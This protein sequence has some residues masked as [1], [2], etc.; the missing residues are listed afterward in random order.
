M[1]HA[2]IL[3]VCIALF[4]SMI[5]LV[6]AQE[7]YTGALKEEIM[8]AWIHPSP[9]IEFNGSPDELDDMCDNS[10]GLPPV[11]NQSSQG[12]CT[13][14]ATAYY[15][16]TYLQWQEHGWDL[17][18]PAHQC[19][20]AFT[21][22]TINGGVDGGSYPSDAFLLF[23][24]SG[25]AT[26]EDMPYDAGDYTRYPSEQAFINGMPFRTLETYSINTYTYSGIQNLKNHL[27]NGNIAET[28]ISVWDNFQNIDNYNYTYCINDVYGD[29]PGGH[30]VTVIGFDDDFETTDGTGA[31][32]MVNS[33]GSSW[34]DDGFWW[35]SY[36]AFMDPLISWG[37][38]LYASD[39]I[40]YEPTMIAYANIE[41]G[42]RYSIKPFMGIGDLVDP[43]LR[44]EYYDFYMGSRAN[45]SFEGTS[46]VLDVSD[47]KM[48]VD[49]YAAND[50]FLEID[51]REPSDGHSGT[52]SDFYLFDLEREHFALWHEVPMILP[53]N[54]ASSY[55]ELVLY[56]SAT[57]PDNLSASIDLST[58]YASLAWDAPTELDDFI[59]YVIYRDGIEIGTSNQ[60]VYTDELPE[61]GIYSYEILT[62]WDEC[63]SWLTDPQA[64]NWIEPVSPRFSRI[65]TLD[66]EGH[67]TF[68]WDQLRDYDLFYDDGTFEAPL[69]PSGDAPPGISIAQKFTAP[70]DGQVL[71]IGAYFMETNPDMNGCIQFVLLEAGNNDLPGEVFFESELICPGQDGWL[72]HDFEDERLNCQLEED[73]WVGIRWQDPGLVRLGLDQDGEVYH[74]KALS[75]NGVNWINMVTV[76]NAMIR[77]KFGNEERVNDWTG[78]LGFSLYLNDEL[79]GQISSDNHIISGSLPEHGLYELRVDANYLQ[80]TWIGSPFVFEWDGQLLDVDKNEIPLTWKIGKAYP[81]P[82][83]PSASI[84]VELQKRA[85]L[86]SFVY[87]IM[88]QQV[89]VLAN[90]H[91]SQGTHRLNFNASHLSSGVYFIRT[92]ITGYLTDTQKVMLVR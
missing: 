42:D 61:F 30:A 60:V 5:P 16:L 56:Y 21:Y 58:G 78:L 11:G 33:W 45:V 44:L 84:E 90:D 39:R 73:F 1:K 76:G 6:Q 63:S 31:F 68:T 32:R 9:F 83:N 79:I 14:W 19:S 40:E 4:I 52:L 23:E 59:E 54:N 49:E 80:G 46:M 43:D 65:S 62:R 64:V 36:E 37:E 57:P 41:H 12:S 13:A 67:F 10:E 89:A 2:C 38:A 50:I 81:N 27:L 34:G 48:Y 55:A 18:D 15:V 53:D 17:T 74:S 28:A 77:T 70:E 29:Q 69:S 82:F 71:S 22:N 26:M 66:E 86:E 35:M 92:S 7:F 3:L 47:L 85:F 87:N 75:I 8:P 88:G 25:C 51:D 24:T 72:W 91:F 20:P